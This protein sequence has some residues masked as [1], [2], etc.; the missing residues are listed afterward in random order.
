MEFIDFLGEMLGIT[1]DFVRNS[2]GASISTALFLR[3]K[4]FNSKRIHLALFS[5][6]KM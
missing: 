2:I 4:R 3:K 5:G 6:K 1:K